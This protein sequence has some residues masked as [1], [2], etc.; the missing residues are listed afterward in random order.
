MTNSR[1]RPIYFF[2][3]DM[4]GWHNKDKAGGDALA[5]CKWTSNG[6]EHVEATA[7]VTFYPVSGESV[8]NRKLTD[9]LKENA[10]VIVCVDA[11]FSWPEAFRRL[12]D[13]IPEGQHRFTFTL[14]DGI[15]NPYLYR[16]T[17]RFIKKHVLKRNPLTAV[18]DKFGNNS[19][20]AQALVRW[21]IDKLPDAY[22]PPF[23]AWERDRAGSNLHSIIE[24]YPA[25]SMK[26]K[27]FK[28]LRWPPHVQDMDQIGSSDIADAKRCAITGVCY[29]R[30]IGV[31]PAG[32]GW[33][34]VYCP[35]HTLVSEKVRATARQEG[36][37]FALYDG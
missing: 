16:E 6:L 14:T 13:E 22:R 37:I 36:W 3:C 2:G 28:K 31:L 12:V 25:A 27:R 23:H 29:A 26:S 34:S 8:L 1:T 10:S 35:D 20:K 4:G 30:E 11:A 33:P 17:D 32:D 24:V 9:A 7:D 18:G 19:S 15:S 5:V 21:F